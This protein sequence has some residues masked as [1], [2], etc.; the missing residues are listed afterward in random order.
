MLHAAV[1][2]WPAFL[3]PQQA[4]F[5]ESER[6]RTEP[7]AEGRLDP[8]RLEGRD[9]AAYP[10]W[11]VGFGVDVWT[12]F[13]SVFNDVVGASLRGGYRLND[14]WSVAARLFRTDFD[15]EDP[16]DNVFG[17]SGTPVV[18]ASIDMIMFS[19][20]AR[21]HFLEP[22]SPL[23]IYVGAGLGLAFPG[24]G[25][26][27]NLPQVDIEVEGNSGPEVH[28]VVGGACRLFEQLHATLELRLMQ[29]F[30][31]Y[32]VRDRLTGESDSEKGW[33]GYGLALGL[34]WRF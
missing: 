7:F 15:F 24:D 6:D 26:A 32:D 10:A 1:L 18:D 27:V 20:T 25:E 11:S 19:A 16:A 5:I 12:G 9:T 34:E 30:T 28:V 21:W 2:L 33:A 13:G 22:K 31:E 23:D 4:E 14:R 29:S 3:A 17:R 8:A